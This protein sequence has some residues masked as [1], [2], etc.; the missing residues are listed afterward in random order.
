MFKEKKRSMLPKYSTC[1]CCSSRRYHFRNRNRVSKR[2]YRIRENSQITVKQF[3]VN[4]LE[5]V[6]DYIRAA[7]PDSPCAKLYN[8]ERLL[9]PLSEAKMQSPTEKVK[10]WL[11]NSVAIKP[12]Y[13]RHSSRDSSSST[14]S[15]NESKRMKYE[16]KRKIPSV[17]QKRSQSPIETITIPSSS[18][19]TEN[20]TR[21]E[22]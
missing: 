5:T 3:I 21:E 6:T 18:S 9:H 17:K 13:H 19:A 15:T 1:R 7:L 4:A 11:Y 2:P 8:L 16:R 12:C 22:E 20:S 14:T 10:S